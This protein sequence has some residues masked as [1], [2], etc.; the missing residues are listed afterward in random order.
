M[1]RIMTKVK[2]EVYKSAK[3]GEFVSKQDIEK[4]PSTT[5]TQ[6]VI[7]NIPSKKK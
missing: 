2:V 3:T 5:Y 4:K 6:T 7:K 1:P